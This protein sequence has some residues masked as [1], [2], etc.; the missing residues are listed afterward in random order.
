M[1]TR[2]PAIYFDGKTAK[3]NQIEVSIEW[4]ALALHDGDVEI[5]RWD[6][7]TLR[8]V[9]GSNRGPAF[10]EVTPSFRSDARLRLDDAMAVKALRQAHPGVDSRPPVNRRAVRKALLW[11][12]GAVGA[13]AFI[14]FVA[15]PALAPQIA[16]LIPEER[17]VA[18]GDEVER[19]VRRFG[20]FG[21]VCDE[22][23]GKAALDKMVAKLSG[24]LDLRL[25]VRADVVESQVVN[26]VA[27]P[28]G[29]V[30]MFMPLIEEAES[31]DEV[32]GVLAH[33]MGHVHNADST[34]EMIRSSASAGVL[35]LFFGDFAGAGVLVGLGEHVSNLSYTRD[36]ERAA[37]DFAIERL[38]ASGTSSE[39]LAAFFRRFRNKGADSGLLSGYL[40][41]HPSFAEREAKLIDGSSD[42]ETEPILT[43]A[44]WRALRGICGGSETPQEDSDDAAD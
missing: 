3:P 5:A 27:L 21:A 37:D 35:G 29:R 24:N 13:L 10:I 16:A 42:G 7:D 11:S 6:Y 23:A 8:R 18:M 12:A 17:E 14:V 9:D 33:E 25:P 40:A 26:A 44:E 2:W 31:A 22:P 19:L 36:A 38:S 39:P 30:L 34:R 4:D 15:I 43:D 32:A 41:S 20:L 28:G 1:K